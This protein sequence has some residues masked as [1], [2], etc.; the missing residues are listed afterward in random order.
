MWHFDRSYPQLLMEHY[1]EYH[2]YQ[3]QQLGYH[4]VSSHHDPSNSE[5]VTTNINTQVT[6]GKMT[7]PSQQESTSD[8]SIHFTKHFKEPVESSILVP[9]FPRGSG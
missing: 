9:V 8:Q 3:Q 7:A 4:P 2:P 6:S 5:H 1:N